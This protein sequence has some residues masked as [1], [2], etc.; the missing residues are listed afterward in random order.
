MTEMQ[1]EEILRRLAEDYPPIVSTAQ[2]AGM[3]GVGVQKLRQMALAGEIPAYRWG[4]N[5]RF[6]RDELIAW[7][8]SQGPESW[9]G[10]DSAIEDVVQAD[11]PLG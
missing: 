4:K 9:A 5:Y 10:S 7:L 1:L 3:L 11:E 8:R 2:A 6:F